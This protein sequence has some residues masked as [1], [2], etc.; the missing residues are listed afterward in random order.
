MTRIWD[1]P[2]IGEALGAYVECPAPKKMLSSGWYG[3]TTDM[4]VLGR[5][6]LGSVIIRNVSHPPGYI[7]ITAV[8]ALVP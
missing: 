5:D 6:E 1:L 2:P 7:R 4:V 8:C 3:P